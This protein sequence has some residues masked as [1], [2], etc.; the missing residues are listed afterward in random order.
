[1]LTPTPITMTDEFSDALAHIGGGDNV[2]ITGKAG[3]GKSTLLRTYLEDTFGKEVLVTAPTGVAALNVDGFTIHR[4]FGFRPGMFPDDITQGRWVVRD[5][6]LTLIDVLVVDEISMVRADLFDM[7]NLAL[8]RAR[9]NSLPF[10]GVQLILVGDLLQ[11]PPVV[12]EKEA[13]LFNSHW[14]SP[15]FFSAHCYPEL[16][17]HTVNLSKVWRQADNEFIEILNQVREGSIDDGALEILNQ[18][19]DENFV[20]PDDWVTVTSYRRGSD[21]INR[22][23]LESVGNPVFTSEAEYSGGANKNSF[24]GT[25]LLHYALGARVMTVIND[26][27]G[28]FVNGSFGTVVAADVDK[29][30]VHLDHNGEVV[31]LGMHTWEAKTPTVTG[32]VI[33]SESAG[34]VRQFPVILAWAIT[35]HK[36]Q[37]KTIPKLF[38]NLAG[39]TRTD[40]QFYVALSRGVSLENLRFSKPVERKHVRANNSLVRQIH[41][42]VSPQVTTRRTV[43]VA[44][45]GVNFGISQHVARVHVIILDGPVKVA[46]FGSWINPMA[47]LGQFGERNRIPAGGLALAPTLGDFWPLLL[48]QAEGGIVIGHNLSTLERAVRHQ[49]KGMDVAL[50]VGYDTADLDFTPAG[51]DVAE[52]C[53]S[54]VEA[55]RAG[56]F[57]IDRG[58]VVPRAPREEEGAVLIPEWAPASPMDLDPQQPSDS[59]AAWAAFSGGTIRPLDKNEVAECA[60]LLSAWGIS[61]GFWTQEDYDFVTARAAKLGAQVDIPAPLSDEVDIASLLTPGTRIAFTGTRTVAGQPGDDDTLKALCAE[62][63]LEMK[64]AVSRTRC[65]VLV[66]ADPASMSRKAQSAREWGKPIISI[67]DFDA[68]YAGALEPAPVI[69]PEPVVEPEPVAEARAEQEWVTPEEFFADGTRVA[70]RG[71]TIIDGTLYPHGE[72]LQSLCDQL[73]LEYKQAV[74]KT[75]SDVLVTDDPHASD[76]K[77]SLARRYGKPMMRQEDFARWAEA[78]LAEIHAEEDETVA[79]AAAPAVEPEP[80]VEPVLEEVTDDPTPQELLARAHKM[81]TT[82][83]Y[84]FIPPTYEQPTPHNMPLVASPAPIVPQPQEN[85][86]AVWFKRLGILSVVL[87]FGGFFLFLLAPDAGAITSLIGLLLL[88]VLAVVGLFALVRKVKNRNERRKMT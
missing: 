36:A 12:D 25:E 23:R 50:G 56:D 21:K 30:T 26:P 10:G 22:E 1:M 48:R 20:A 58:Q 39:G 85:K 63:G 68:W 18:Q 80:V 29:I 86:P 61:R 42:E 70:F 60:E 54:M 4:A 53:E 55:F 27:M 84:G 78:Q 5:D 31:D 46:D 41:R 67:E 52:R 11:L 19:V 49:E 62:K 76:G 66:A 33:S 79:V 81:R 28:R 74:T 47:D 40:G 37:G 83:D 77:M 64:T 24:T 3:T 32:G 7:M 72:Q 9:S 57:V 34:K 69:E 43:F 75:R 17:L 35:I 44:F 59:D 73:G 2:L 38:I 71:S 13:E 88:P 8:Q 87:F 82:S 14:V 15:Y 16:D 51:E 65:D 6:V 45:D